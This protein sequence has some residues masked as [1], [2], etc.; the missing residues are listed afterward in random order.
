MRKEKKF[1]ELIEPI[2]LIVHTKCPEKWILLDRETGQ[3]YK[4]NVKGYWYR[5]DP[6]IKNKDNFTN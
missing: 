2:D 3:T 5:L 6:I 4:G 1:K